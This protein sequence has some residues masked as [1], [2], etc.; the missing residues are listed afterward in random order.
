MNKK[1]N[2]KFLTTIELFSILNIMT[3]KLIFLYTF[4]SQKYKEFTLSTNVRHLPN[5]CKYT[6]TLMY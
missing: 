5:C 1:K 2:L 4:I 6:F 3:V